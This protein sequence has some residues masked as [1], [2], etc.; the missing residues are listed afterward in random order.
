MITGDK[1]LR[2][3][4][5]ISGQINKPFQWGRMDCNILIAAANDILT[6]RKTL[7]KIYGKYNDYRSAIKFQK[8]YLSAGQYLHANGWKKITDPEVRDGD[9]LLVD[10]R[11]FSRAHIVVNGNVWSVHEEFGVCAANLGAMPEYTHWRLQ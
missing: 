5:L 3:T 7:H 1:I 4:G 8:N 11:H 2:L 10:D 9:V 6:G